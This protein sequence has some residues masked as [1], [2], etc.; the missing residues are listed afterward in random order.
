MDLSVIKD[1]A[2]I[3]AAIISIIG[4]NTWKRQL[5][6]NSEYNLA[7]KASISLYELREVIIQVRNPFYH[8]NI[9]YP[10]DDVLCKFNTEQWEQI[11]SYR[12]RKEHQEFL[13]MIKFAEQDL[14]SCLTVIDLVLDNNLLDKI[15][16]ISILINDLVYAK[17]EV[18]LYNIKQG[19]NHT[20][21]NESDVKR[22]QK[23]KKINCRDIDSKIKDDFMEEFEQAILDVKNALKLHI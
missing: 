4:L 17:N 1:F 14:K 6:G 11:E 8:P 16:A 15:K 10:D 5:K 20:S 7:I 19:R 12:I 3:I 22:I 2:I 13:K 23:L 18:W 9:K 21:Y